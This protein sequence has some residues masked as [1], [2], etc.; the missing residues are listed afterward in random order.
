[1][2]DNRGPWI[3]AAAIVLAAALMVG[4][5]AFFRGQDQSCAEWQS[6]WDRTVQSSAQ[7]AFARGLS[8]E[9]AGAEYED[10]AR[11]LAEAQP[12][13]CPLP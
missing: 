5:W 7:E 12:D 8:P 3:I 9:E 11:A 13:G 10:E 1:M 6:E 4:A 2:A